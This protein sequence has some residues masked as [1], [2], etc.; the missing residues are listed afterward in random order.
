MKMVNSKRVASTL[1]Y[2]KRVDDEIARELSKLAEK[3]EEEDF[4]DSSTWMLV[5]PGLQ[6]PHR[7]SEPPK[8]IERSS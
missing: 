6:V 7:W 4:V 3:A 5:K 2:K 8:W 1:K